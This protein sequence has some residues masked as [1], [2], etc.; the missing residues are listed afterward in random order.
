MNCNQMHSVP[1]ILHMIRSHDSGTNQALILF[2]WRNIFFHVNFA[3]LLLQGGISKQ[4]LQWIR[5]QTEPLL[6]LI[7][8]QCT[9][10]DMTDQTLHINNAYVNHC[11]VAKLFFCL[12][13]S[14]LLPVS[15]QSLIH[16]HNDHDG[17]DCYLQ[18]HNENITAAFFNLN[19]NNYYIISLL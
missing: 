17:I 14:I 7:N 9:T 3:F 1:F 8:D 5:L 15:F 2:L 12:S 16:L 13:N 4:V 10:C 18:Q 11:A 19:Y 6:F